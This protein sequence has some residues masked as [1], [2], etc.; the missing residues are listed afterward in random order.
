MQRMV[1]ILLCLGVLGVVTGCAV[2][3]SVSGVSSPG[4]Y[5][6]GAYQGAPSSDDG[7]RMHEA[8]QAYRRQES[9]QGRGYWQWEQELSRAYKATAE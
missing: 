8:E 1:L 3:S 4:R 5:G 7:S 2:G 6:V 9:T